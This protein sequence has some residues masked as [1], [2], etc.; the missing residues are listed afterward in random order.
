VPG[1]SRSGDAKT[2]STASQQEEPPKGEEEASGDR[3]VSNL[4]PNVD[5]WL[6]LLAKRDQELEA[7]IKALEE[8]N[9]SDV[10]GI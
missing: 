9:R 8:Q 2:A 4:G 10:G 1:P 7:R 6:E 3:I 5:G